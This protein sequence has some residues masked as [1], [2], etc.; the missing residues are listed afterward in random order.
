[1]GEIKMVQTS[2]EKEAQIAFN[3]LNKLLKNKE[4]H[5]L[6]FEHI[7]AIEYAQ[8]AILSIEALCRMKW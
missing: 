1:V 8:K 6:S 3:C 2:I 4:K 5:K 7:K